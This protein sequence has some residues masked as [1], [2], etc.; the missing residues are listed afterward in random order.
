MCITCT[1]VYPEADSPCTSFAGNIQVSDMSLNWLATALVVMC[2][3]TDYHDLM[4]RASEVYVI[5]FI[6]QPQ[7]L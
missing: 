3:P 5:A 6:R 2:L 7:N 1:I 4:I